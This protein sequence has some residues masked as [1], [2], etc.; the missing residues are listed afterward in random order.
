MW[1]L[2]QPFPR[3]IFQLCYHLLPCHQTRLLMTPPRADVTLHP[4]WGEVHAVVIYPC[5]RF[6]HTT[7][8]GLILKLRTFVLMAGAGAF[9]GDTTD[10]KRSSASVSENGLKASASDDMVVDSVVFM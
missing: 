7:Y 6:G 3:Q 4:S 1:H 5:Q 9:F 2:L 10:V 8:D